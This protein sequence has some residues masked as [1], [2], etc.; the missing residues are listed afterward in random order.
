MRARAMLPEKHI[1]I[2]IITIKIDG[3]QLHRGTA[4]FADADRIIFYRSVYAPV[5]LLFGNYCV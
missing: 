3:S 5:Q 1:I 4:L 2:I